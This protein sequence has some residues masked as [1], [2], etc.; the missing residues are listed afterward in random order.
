MCARARAYRLLRGAKEQQLLIKQ[1]N[2]KLQRSLLFQSLETFKDI[3]III[4]NYISSSSRIFLIII[5]I[6]VTISHI[7]TGQL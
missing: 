7:Y 1:A 4:I 3:I 6:S 2:H 5:F